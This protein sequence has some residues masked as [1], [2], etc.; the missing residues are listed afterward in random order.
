MHYYYNEKIKV[1]SPEEFYRKIKE[2]YLFQNVSIDKS[3][4]ELF[5]F[6]ETKK[7]DVV[8]QYCLGKCY[9]EG[10]G[11]TKDYNKAIEWY[12]EAAEQGYAIAQYN[13]GVYY[14]KVMVL[15]KILIKLLNG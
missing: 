5:K 2:G 12:K 10:I 7:D 15:H 13:L 9:F 11:V 4:E 3:K 14:A 1:N 8:G 6:L